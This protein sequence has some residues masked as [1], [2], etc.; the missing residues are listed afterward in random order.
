MPS[1]IEIDLVVSEM[2]RVV[3]GRHNILIMFSY[4]LC[5]ERLIEVIF[6]ER[7]GPLFNPFHAEFQLENQCHRQL[8][9][10]LIE[11]QVS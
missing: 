11:K 2:K 9:L 6:I 8:Q 3:V 10:T 5:K 4:Y 7:R 1:F